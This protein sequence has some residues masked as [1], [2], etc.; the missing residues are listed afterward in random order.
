[1]EQYC[2]YTGEK[3][4]TGEMN[5]EHIIPL[6]LGGSDDFSIF[7]SE[8]LNSYVGS[9][10]DGKLKNDVML[11]LALNHQNFK[12]HSKKEQM[13]NIKKA[14]ENG[15]PV[16][17]SI[18]K[19]HIEVYD[20]I[21]K[22]TRLNPKEVTLEFRMDRD[23]RIRFVAKVA[24]ATGYFLFKENFI[25]NADHHSLRK[26]V[27]NDDVPEDSTL[28]IITPFGGVKESDA[29]HVEWLKTVFKTMKGASVFYLVG[30]NET[31]VEVGL[32]ENYIASIIFKSENKEKMQLIPNINSY[33]INMSEGKMSIIP[34]DWDEINR[35]KAE[36]NNV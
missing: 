23:V 34:I 8:E 5:K 1:M 19:N 17:V 13:V 29:E 30:D 28:R 26:F 4:A 16:S 27:F 9:K 2:I 14:S 7:V 20:P 10:V 12:G 31:I 24:L 36:Y 21:R 15:S 33:F 11:G 18:K 22:E 35:M 32:A 25:E 6:S 3:I